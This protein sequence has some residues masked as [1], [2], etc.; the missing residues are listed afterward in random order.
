MKPSPAPAGQGWPLGRRVHG[1]ELEAAALQVEGVEFIE[2]LAVAGRLADDSGWAAPASVELLP[3]ELPWLTEI[4]VVVGADLPVPGTAQTP[5][6][7]S[8]PVPVPVEREEC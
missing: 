4:A 6:R 8:T 5:P 7:A 2:G 3:H 1:P